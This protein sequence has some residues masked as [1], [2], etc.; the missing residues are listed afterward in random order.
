MGK[1]PWGVLKR[2]EQYNVPVIAICGCLSDNT[3]F[4]VLQFKDIIQVTPNDMLLDEAML[5]DVA[6]NNVRKAV[7]KIA[8]K[9]LI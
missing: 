1:T 5:P 4:N 8:I 7:S 6:K 3:D 2:A 9:Y